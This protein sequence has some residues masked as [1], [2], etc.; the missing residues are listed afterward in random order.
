[1]G[2]FECEFVENPPEKFPQVDCPVCLSILREPHQ[3]T[4]CGN[5]FCRTCIE[6]VKKKKKACPT[7]NEGEL[8]Y[9]PDKRLQRSLY[10]FKVYCTERAGGCG[11]SGELGNLDN[12]LKQ[13]H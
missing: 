2:G 8:N 7:C 9:F 1:M 6:R 10:A 5:N 11:W 12:H 3:V 4:C 13:V